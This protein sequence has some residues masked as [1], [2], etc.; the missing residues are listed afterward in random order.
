MG[1]SK[2]HHK[3]VQLTTED[4]FCSKCQP[5]FYDPFSVE[6]EPEPV[7]SPQELPISSVFEDLDAFGLPLREEESEEVIFVKKRER[8]I[9]SKPSF[10]KPRRFQSFYWLDLRLEF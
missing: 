10:V 1:L 7:I 2:E 4:W 5:D 6:A 3:I 8:K 9:F